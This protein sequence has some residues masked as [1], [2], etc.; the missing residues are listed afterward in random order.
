MSIG[1]PKVHLSKYGCRLFLIRQTMAHRAT[2]P[3]ADTALT[4]PTD[5]GKHACPP[6]AWV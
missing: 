6:V 3:S 4:M 2:N 5:P 1:N